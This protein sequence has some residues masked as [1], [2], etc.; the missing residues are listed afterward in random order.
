MMRRISAITI[1]PSG[2]I[3][4]GQ[5]DAVIRLWGDDMSEVG[6]ILGH[7]GCITSLVA[8]PSGALASGSQDGTVKV[9][10][11]ASRQSFITLRGHSPVMALAVLPDGRLASVSMDQR[12]RVWDAEAAIEAVC[13]WVDGLGVLAL[14]VLPCRTVVTGSRDGV[15]RLWTHTRTT[16]DHRPPHRCLGTGLAV[17]ELRLRKPC[18]SRT[19]TPGIVASPK[20]RMLPPISATPR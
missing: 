11:V 18:G 4:S 13:L 10:N 14:A 3:A 12:L 7:G 8:L 19:L 16:K 17:E 15:I 9:W 6:R 5:G 20:P 2:C 1:L